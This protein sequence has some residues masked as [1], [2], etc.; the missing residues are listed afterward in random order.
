M[1]GK[2]QN[3]VWLL[4]MLVMGG[5]IGIAFL[6]LDGRSRPAPLVIEPPPPTAT[7]AP[8]TTPQ[9]L[10]V[11]VSGA[12]VRPDVYTLAPGSI[13]RDLVVMAGNFTAE[14]A[15]GS[16]NLAQPL[17]DGMHVHVPAE[18]EVVSD[19][20]VISGP[21]PPANSFTGDGVARPGAL[22]NINTA[23]IAELETLPGIGPS[24]AQQII[25]HRAAHGP[26]ATVEAILDVSGIG[27]A[28]FEQIKEH[29][30]VQ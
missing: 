8:T 6:S 1:D 11:Y 28:R 26:F 16:V 2:K 25:D 7:P 4:V 18:A 15:A 29:I 27:P 22:V 17:V 5:A 23:S 13:V 30:T 12:V 21:A 9:P 19:P 3:V 24:L 10:R 20:P 14:A